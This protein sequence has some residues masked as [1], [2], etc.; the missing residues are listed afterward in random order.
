MRLFSYTITHDFGSAPNPYWG[1]CTLT[2]CKPVIRRVAQKRDWV[3]G[4]RGDSVVYAM[5]ITDRKTLAE[6]DRYCRGSLQRK[7][8]DWDSRDCARRAGDCIYDFSA[9]GKPKLRDGI[10]QPKNVKT[11]LSGLNA[12]LSTDFYYFGSSAIPLPGSL[13]AIIQ[14]R[15]HRSNANDPYKTEFVRWVRT[16]RSV[17]NRVVADPELKDK[18]VLPGARSRCS[19]SDRK[20]AEADE[21][22][23]RHRC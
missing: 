21:R 13:R 9:G 7:I 2:I 1:V 19:S 5:R 8:P 23:V 10:H 20:E 14:K 4:L 12:L 3:V 16:H 18:L 15:G 11:D 17:H 22:R 6:Y